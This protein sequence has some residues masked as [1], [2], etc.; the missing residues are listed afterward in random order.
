MHEGSYAKILGHFV[1]YKPETTRTF[2]H[3]R[4]DNKYGRTLKRTI[5]V[6]LENFWYLL[7]LTLR[8]TM[9]DMKRRS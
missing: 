5:T 1:H 7:G 2:K 8:C 3:R 6:P 4:M 9:V